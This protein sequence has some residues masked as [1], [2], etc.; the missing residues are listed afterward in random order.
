MI[1][2]AILGS[3]MKTCD[4]NDNI[5]TLSL[6]KPDEDMNKLNSEF[7]EVM[8]TE[9]QKQLHPTRQTNSSLT[10]QFIDLLLF[11]LVN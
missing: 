10:F 4:H 8:L 7:L 3:Q 6:S 5:I 2:L 1:S 11:Y 9:D